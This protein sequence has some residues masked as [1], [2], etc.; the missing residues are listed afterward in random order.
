[1]RQLPIETADARVAAAQAQS[2][3]VAARIAADNAKYGVTPGDDVGLIQAA[4]RTERAARV[5][6]CQA[7]VLAARLARATAE[8][9]PADQADRAAQLDAAVKQVAAAESALAAASTALEDAA[10]DATYTAF[11]PI[12]PTQSSGRRKALAEWMT[13]PDNP[14]TPRVA[15]NHIWMRHFGEP[16][17]QSVNNFGR[18]G[19]PPSHPELLDWLTVEFI[20]SGWSMK[21][22]HRLIVTSA[23]YRQASSAAPANDAEAAAFAHNDEVDPDNIYL[24]RMHVRRMEAEVVRD[25]LLAIAGKLD[26]TMGG[27]ELENGDALTTFRRSLYYSCHPEGDGKSALGRLFDG[28]DAVDCYRRT[29]TVI[30]Q[31]AL[32]LTNSDLIHSQSADLAARLFAAVSAADDPDGAFIERAFVDMLTRRPTEQELMICREYLQQQLAQLQQ[33]GVADPAAAARASLVRVL[34]NHNDFLAIR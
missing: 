18:N 22:L 27:Q 21:H 26:L 10:Q 28:A 31:Q 33:D 32:A 30:P 23:A 2:A 12:Y 9:L 19:S 14:L 13:R 16:L 17:V 24:W 3:G 20:E 4:S 1:M 34:F 11:S 7:D 25:S 29:E 5:A 8:L 6:S 15:V